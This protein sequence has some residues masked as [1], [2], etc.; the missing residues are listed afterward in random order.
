MK[1]IKL[2]AFVALLQIAAL[3][4]SAQIYDMREM[5][6]TE[7]AALDRQKTVV[8][9]PEGI[10]EEH[11]P[12]LPS[13]TDGYRNEYFARRVAEAIV[14]RPGWSVL[15]FPPIPL[16]DGGGNQIGKWQTF[17]GTYHVHFSTLRSMFMD[18]ASELGEGGFRRIFVISV[19]GA[20]QHQLALDQASDF[21]NETYGGTMVYLTGLI[22]DSPIAPQLNLTDN[23]RREN[24]LDVHG[25]MNE[26]SQM[27]FL[28]PDLVQPGYKTAQ[29]HSG[30]NWRDLVNRGAEPNWPGYLGSPRL[31][32][33][34]RGA[35]IMRTRA[36]ELSALALRILDG[37][38]FRTLQR[39]SVQQQT[40]EAIRDYDAAA[41]AHARQIQQQQ[42]SWLQ[43][44]GLK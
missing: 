26:T 25:G 40:D 31:A 34:A 24:G 9:I 17:P 37:F 8:I 13:Y 1:L 10:L 33:A 7:N 21:F 6:T 36:Q 22:P 15:I 2:A 3:P 42:D 16:G 27:L 30:A 32:T 28:R 29:P 39:T 5:N 4:A 14:A 43:R 38:D 19:H 12:Y 18:I 11:G 20:P 35:E 44:K 41:N 23:E